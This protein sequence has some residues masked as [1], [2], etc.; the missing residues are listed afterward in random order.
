MASGE[1]G[2]TECGAAVGIFTDMKGRLMLSFGF[3]LHHPAHLIGLVQI[4]HAAGVGELDLCR[5]PQRA[6]SRNPGAVGR[7]SLLAR[8]AIVTKRTQ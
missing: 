4:V 6:R 3:A 7:A 8:R 5:A 2:R 1:V